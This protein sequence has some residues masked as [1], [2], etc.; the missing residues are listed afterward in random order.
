MSVVGAIAAVWIGC[1]VAVVVIVLLTVRSE[2]RAE[3]RRPLAPVVELDVSRAR[4]RQA[5][6][7]GWA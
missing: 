2:R 5:R 7:R 1:F 6:R 3:R 4:R